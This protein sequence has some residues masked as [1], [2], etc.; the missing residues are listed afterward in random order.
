[1]LE[2]VKSMDCDQAWTTLHLLHPFLLPPHVA[3]AAA[4][5]NALHAVPGSWSTSE[6]SRITVPAGYGWI[7]LKA[8]ICFEPEPSGHRTVSSR[9][10]GSKDRGNG[11][12]F[13]HQPGGWA[14]GS[15]VSFTAHSPIMPVVPG[16]YFEL[17][18]LHDASRELW[19]GGVPE[20]DRGPSVAAAYGCVYFE[21]RFY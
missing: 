9:R 8:G 4:W 19:I 5:E 20:A 16:D 2:D 11:H 21:A 10:N 12:L 17:L 13:G 6:P 15:S 14:T 18:V 1:L 7:E 3:M